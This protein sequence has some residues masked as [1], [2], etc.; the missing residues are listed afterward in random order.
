MNDYF[1]LFFRSIYCNSY[2]TLYIYIYNQVKNKG[3]N[4]IMSKYNK[5]GGDVDLVS[6]A[7]YVKTSSLKLNNWEDIITLANNNYF[8]EEDVGFETKLL[9]GST[10]YDV[11]LIG[12]NHD[13]KVLGGKANT[14]WQLK[15]CYNTSY[16][17]NSSSTN[18]GGY[19][20]SA[21]HTT[22]LPSIFNQIQ[23]DVKSAIKPVIKKT[24]AGGGSTDIVNVNCNLFLLSEMEIFGVNGLQYGNVN[25]GTQ[26]KYWKINNNNG[27]R[28][29]G[30]QSSPS[31]HTDWWER[32]PRN[33]YTGMFCCVG[34]AG[35]ATYNSSNLKT[36][37]SFAFCI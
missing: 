14:T 20:S 32:S 3:K 28:Q 24:T 11:V 15:N 5:I 36:A 18:N 33:S 17:M 8:S 26:Y 6:I 22:R 29:K 21:M 10:S 4:L 1:Y 13:D 9:I 27:S 19:G 25:E 30:L 2:F 7:K 23:S 12:V 16:S 35:T 34:V 31:S 37:V